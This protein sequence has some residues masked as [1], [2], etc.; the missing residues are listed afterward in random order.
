MQH[1]FVH[2]GACLKLVFLVSRD[3]QWYA[4]NIITELRRMN[5]I[6]HVRIMKFDEYAPHLD[7]ETVNKA[8]K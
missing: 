2:E 7:L 5:Q 3:V 6:R 8:T 4:R 1:Y